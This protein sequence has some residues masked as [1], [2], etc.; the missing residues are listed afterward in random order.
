GNYAQALHDPI[1]WKALGNTLVF[2]V[3]GGPLSV[4]TS[5][6]AALL[7]TSRLARFPGLYRSIFFLPVVTTLVAVAIVWRYLF[8][9]QYGLL[10]WMLGGLGIHPVGCVPQ[11]PLV[12]FAVHAPG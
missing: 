8:H 12:P 6:A 4:A 2:V 3:V 7:V 9:T 11:P 1:F 5:L 10:N